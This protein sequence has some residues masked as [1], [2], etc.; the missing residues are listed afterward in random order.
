MKIIK[1]ISLS[2]LFAALIA[3]F[4][5]YICHIPIGV[6]GGYIHFGDTLIYL[7][8]SLLP[9]PYAVMAAAV[10]AG[11][12]DLLTAPVW[13]LPSVIIKSLICLSFTNKKAKI[14]CA[15]NIIALFVAAVITPVGYAVAETVIF[16][17]W[18]VAVTS[19]PANLFQATA[20]AIFF[21]LMGIALDKAKINDKIKL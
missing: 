15:R 10:G 4:T 13:V 3:L 6:N 21:V 2:A 9:T 5:A 20:S 11:L 7:A 14:I 1:K 12:A 18:L 16:G 19:M 17:N 8:A